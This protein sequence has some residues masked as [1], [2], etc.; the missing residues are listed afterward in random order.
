MIL[1][2]TVT[3]DDAGKNLKHILKT[4][5]KISERLLKKL[6]YQNKITLNKVLAR[7]NQTVS[8]YD[9]VQVVLE[10]EEENEDVIPQNIPINIIYEDDCM[11]V[12]NK[13]PGIVVHPTCS[14]PD[15]TIANG[16]V[17]YLR[18][19]GIIKKVRPVS[20]L[21][22]DTSG[23]IIFA[24][25]QFTQEAL[26][27]QM[28]TGQFQKNYIGIVHGIPGVPSGTID[29]PIERKPGSIMERWVSETG[30]KAVTHYNVLESFPAHD[31]S[32]IEFKLETGRTHQI[33]VHC[34][35]LGI[36]L[37][38]ET[39]YSDKT[40]LLISRQ[41]L[42]SYNTKIIHPDLQKEVEF[43]APYPSDICGLLEILRQ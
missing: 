29:L 36:P 20:R 23:I 38:G 2:Y 21:D 5:L 35:A 27:R 9:E 22:R 11:L 6:K 18:Q 1:N 8:E 30:A 7:V 14:H 19:K 26:I 17:Y 4:R 41:A 28:R 25:N 42:H 39:L 24:K 40:D 43:A 16:I 32:L 10:L 34:Q 33:R 3:A 13:Q 37:F 15:G 31:A 12:L